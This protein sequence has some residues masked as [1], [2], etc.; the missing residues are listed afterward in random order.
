MCSSDLSG[1]ETAGSGPESRDQPQ[2]AA[3]WFQSTAASPKPP[4]AAPA[5]A[6][7]ASMLVLLVDP[8]GPEMWNWARIWL[9]GG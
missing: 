2:S 7:A 9:P 4:I 3:E 1:R 5:V 6:G 8:D